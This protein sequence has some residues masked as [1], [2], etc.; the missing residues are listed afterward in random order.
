M[1]PIVRGKLRSPAASNAGSSMGIAIDPRQGRQIA[2][3]SLHETSAKKLDNQFF[4][5]FVTQKGADRSYKVSFSRPI[6]K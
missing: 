5:F 3:P 4:F 1:P 2:N 6:I